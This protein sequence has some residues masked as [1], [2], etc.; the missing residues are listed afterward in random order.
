MTENDE[1]RVRARAYE[2]WEREGRPD[3]RAEDHWRDAER[4]LSNGQA[5]TS[6]QGISNHPPGEERDRQEHMPPRSTKREANDTS[7]DSPQP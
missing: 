3:G 1:A 7:E 5:E 4:E 6:Q 2:Q